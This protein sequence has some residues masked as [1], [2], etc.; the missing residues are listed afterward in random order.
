[1]CRGVADSEEMLK[2]C[3]WWLHCTL[4]KMSSIFVN[5]LVLR[6]GERESDIDIQW[7]E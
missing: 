1:M 2:K 5:D 7:Y 3:Y 6:F 4:Y